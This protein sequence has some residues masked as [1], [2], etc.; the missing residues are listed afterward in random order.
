[1]CY[2]KELKFEYRIKESKS[3]IWRRILKSQGFW[4]EEEVFVE[5]VF[6]SQ[7]SLSPCGVKLRTTHWRVLLK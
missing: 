5:V 4:I 3:L 2:I 7:E 1:M 6:L